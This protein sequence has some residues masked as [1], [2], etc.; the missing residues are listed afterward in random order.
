M[1][2][3]YLNSWKS[4]F[5]VCQFIVFETKN[6]TFLRL[7]CDVSVSAGHVLLSCVYLTSYLT[8]SVLEKS[9]NSIFEIPVILQSL[10]INNQRTTCTKSISLDITG[11]LIEYSL[12]KFCKFD[13]YFV[14]FKILLFEGRSVLSPAQRGT[15]R[16]RVKIALLKPLFLIFFL[17]PLSPFSPFLYSVSSFSRD[18]SSYN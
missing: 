3:K 14:V 9:K 8:L 12:K 7:L 5:L 4:Y 1:L 16:K 6:K 13:V 17:I 10:N 15:G 11:K 18:K 2:K